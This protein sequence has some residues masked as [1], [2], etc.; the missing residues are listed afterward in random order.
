MVTQYLADLEARFSAARLRRYQS[1]TGNDLETTVNYLWNLA[2][3][4]SLYCS[5]NVVEVGLRNAIHNSLTAHFGVPNWYDR[6]GLLE[7]DQA[8]EVAR[9]K[10]RIRKYGR[11]ITPDR[12]VSELGFGFW[13]TILSRTYDARFWQASRQATLRRAFPRVPRRKRQRVAIHAHYNA[14]RELR[15]RVFHHEPLF[16]DRRLRLRHRDIHEAIR[17]IDPLL[18][19]RIQ[20]FD[21]FT[22]V[23]DRGRME[24]ENRLKSHLDMP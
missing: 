5:L 24:V 18:V 3:A 16:D 14:I 13:V 11:Q 23:Y 9:M 4:E 8:Q 22:D 19:E 1:G 17:W 6:Q 10:E 21:R 7:P 20:P 15:N 12:V 2:L